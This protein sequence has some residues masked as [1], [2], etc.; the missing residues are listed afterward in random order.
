MPASGRP[1]LLLLALLPLVAMWAHIMSPSFGGPNRCT[2]TYMHPAFFPVQLEDPGDP[3]RVDVDARISTHEHPST[4][5]QLSSSSQRQ[6]PR[7]HPSRH[8]HQPHGLFRDWRGDTPRHLHRHGYSLYL[9]KERPDPQ[10]TAEEAVRRVGG[11]GG[12]SRSFPGLFLPGN[13][14]SYRQVRSI[15]A[16]SSRIADARRQRQGD[17]AGHGE[18]KGTDHAD[19]E[20]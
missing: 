16:E 5:A 19:L 10:L 2:M 17:G 8:Q 6:H 11:G 9:Y 14:G 15:A 4:G 1:I 12:G 20:P 13:G 3:R 7:Q 18:E